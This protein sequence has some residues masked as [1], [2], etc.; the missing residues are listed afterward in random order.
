[1]DYRDHF[2]GTFENYLNLLEEAIRS[3][4]VWAREYEALW[5]GAA[6]NFLYYE[7]EPNGPYPAEKLRRVVERVANTGAKGVVLFCE[8][9]LHRYGLWDA[10]TEIFNG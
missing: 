5:I 1:M 10:A 8:G 7:E 6:I 2:P 4:Q 3:Q 9:H